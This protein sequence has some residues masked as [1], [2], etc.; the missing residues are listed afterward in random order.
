MTLGEALHA[1]A[2]DRQDPEGWETVMSELA[3][4][5]RGPSVI[6]A[7][8]E[9]SE[10]FVL[11][12]LLSEVGQ[13][14]WVEG[15][16]HPEAYVAKML[17]NRSRSLYRREKRRRE[18]EER[19]PAPVAPSAPPPPAPH[20]GRLEELYRTALKRRQARYRPHL[21][22]AWEDL[23]SVLDGGSLADAISA[24]GEEPDKKALNKAYKAQ[25]RLRQAFV[26]VIEFRVWAEKW[27]QEDGEVY[28]EEVRLLLRCQGRGFSGVFRAE[29][30]HDD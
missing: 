12:K 24:R 3:L 25:E 26:D 19:G 4:L 22:A 5:A 1:L 16:D 14:G 18:V 2:A 27:S 21:E 7:H 30:R 13:P 29:V 17:I 11:E 9:E 20:R 15:I 28:L 10:G 23:Q 6:P 8:R